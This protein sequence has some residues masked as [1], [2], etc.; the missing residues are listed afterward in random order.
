MEGAG[1][2]LHTHTLHTHIH[3]YSQGISVWRSQAH[4]T[5]LC[6]NSG[7][8]QVHICSESSDRRSRA[9]RTFLEQPEIRRSSTTAAPLTFGFRMCTGTCSRFIAGSLYPLAFISVLCNI[10]LFFP[11]WSV[12][13][14]RDGY[15]TEEVKYMGGLVGGGLMVSSFF[16]TQ[17]FSKGSLVEEPW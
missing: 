8:A 12:Q 11:G 2:P 16:N 6:V 7:W 14:A 1:V 17:K 3:T 5:T 9:A 13:Y 4:P 15:L 10:I